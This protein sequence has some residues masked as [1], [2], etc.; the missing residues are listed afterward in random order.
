MGL[1]YSECITVVTKQSQQKKLK[2]RWST[3]GAMR[4][5]MSAMARNYAYQQLGAENAAKADNATRL[6]EVIEDAEEMFALEDLQIEEDNNALALS[7]AR[8]NLQELLPV[9]HIDRSEISTYSFEFSKVIVV[10]GPDGLVA[11]VAKY[12][13]GIP[14]IGVNPDRNRYDGILVPFVDSQVFPLV[15]KVLDNRARTRRVTLAKVQTSDE[16][17]MLAFNDF[18]VGANSH[19]SARY[20]L[21]FSGQSESQS[22]SGVL[23]STG[24]GSTGW[25]SSIFNMVNAINAAN[26]NRSCDAMQMS[27]NDQRLFWCVRE[28][29]VSRSSTANQTCGVLEHGTELVLGSQMAENGTIFSDGIEEDFI[30]FNT[31]VIARISVADEKAILVTG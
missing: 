13:P 16:Q 11:N 3:K 22:S 27:P 9:S 25:M 6:Q 2:R 8:R 12:A 31:G 17:E 10:I 21:E 20:S 15:Q 19:V 4:Y 24:A 28:P 1:S 26:G 5:R 7:N 14:I 29:F 30:E 23:I 18:F